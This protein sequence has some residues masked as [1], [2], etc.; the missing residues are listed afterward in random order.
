MIQAAASRPAI[1]E[2]VIRAQPIGPGWVLAVVSFMSTM[3]V[4]VSGL[5]VGSS[6]QT[7]SV[8][9]RNPT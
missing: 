6:P 9:T 1:E 2:P 5:S 8:E 7:G 3:V 4:L